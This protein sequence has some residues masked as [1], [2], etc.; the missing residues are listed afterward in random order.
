VRQTRIDRPVDKRRASHPTIIFVEVEAGSPKSIRETKPSPY[1]V[2]R[3]EAWKPAQRPPGKAERLAN[4]LDFV[5]HS[6]EAARAMLTPRVDSDVR[7]NPVDSIGSSTESRVSHSEPPAF[8]SVS[9]GQRRLGEK[10]H[11]ACSVTPGVA[12]RV[13]TQA[14]R[15]FAGFAD[16][17]VDHD[18]TAVCVTTAFL[19][20]LLRR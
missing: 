20:P 15:V 14:G 6:D 4:Y 8:C 2:N 19:V 5:R 3:R 11:R 18:I 9:E 7:C 10:E 13:R 17:I 1:P 12:L 16:V